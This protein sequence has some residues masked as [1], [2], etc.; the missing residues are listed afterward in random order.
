M[1]MIRHE[2]VH[3]YSNLFLGRTAQ[4]LRSN[5]IDWRLRCEYLTAAICAETQGIAIKPEI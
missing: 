2:A 3:D 5:E 1:Q 4:N